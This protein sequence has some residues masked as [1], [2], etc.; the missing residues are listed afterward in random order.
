MPTY[1]PPPPP[2]TLTTGDPNYALAGLG[3]G[4]GGVDSVIAYGS[5][6]LNVRDWVDTIL[7][8]NIDGLGDADIRD[9]RDVNPGQHGETAFAAYYGGRTIVITG[10][11]RAHTL[12]KLRDMQTGLRATFS[13]LSGEQALIFKT[14]DITTDIIINCKKSQSLVMAEAQQTQ[15]RFER[16]FQVTLRAS[17]PRFLSYLEVVSQAIYG[18]NEGFTDLSQWT[19]DSGFSG[20]VTTGSQL[21]ATSTAD[22]RIYDSGY[23][24]THADWRETMKVHTGASVTGMGVSMGS[25]I[26]NRN[27]LITE[28]WANG[29]TSTLRI[30][31]IDAGAPFTLWVS[32]ANFTSTVNTDYWLRTVKSGNVVTASIYTSDPSV[33]S[34]AALATVTYTL[35]TTDITKFGTGVLGSPLIR[36]NSVAS[37]WYA[38]NFVY[39]PVV[40]RVAYVVTNRGNFPAQPTFRVYGPL[41][42]AAA[43]G[44]AARI[45]NGTTGTTL[46]LNA[47]SGSTVAVASGRYIEIDTARRTMKEYDTSG[48]YIG[49]SFSQ[50]DVTSDWPTLAAD[51]NSIELHTYAPGQP[52]LELHH[53]HTWM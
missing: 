5:T 4:P 24:Y 7:I 15:G 50:L 48:N 27:A 12:D 1:V 19:Y 14:G 38:D 32:S 28:F 44:P 33:G 53:R 45:Y 9:A 39:E 29:V 11:I 30:G 31:R 34:P 21:S 16:D 2:V 36:F 23:L 47:K 42:A 22:R 46:L 43:G 3:T 49:N 52:S 13:D 25:R 35:L 6:L 10:K 20:F 37:D 18:V 41:N 51:K 26:D 40:D 17:N 8:T